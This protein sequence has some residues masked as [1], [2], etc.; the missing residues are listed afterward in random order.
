MILFVMLLP[1]FVMAGNGVLKE[2]IN[3][4]SSEAAK[5][6]GYNILVR[7]AVSVSDISVP[8]TMTIPALYE[9]VIGINGP[10]HPNVPN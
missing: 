9:T 10:V 2:S 3:W 8:F 4:A 5:T 6:N 1:A 7:V